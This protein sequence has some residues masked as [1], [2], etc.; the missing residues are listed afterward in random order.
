MPINSELIRYTELN[1][2]TL[3]ALL[4]DET[5]SDKDRSLVASAIAI[6]NIR[7]SADQEQRINF[8]SQHADRVTKVYDEKIEDLNGDI[9]SLKGNLAEQG[10]ELDKNKADLQHAQEVHR[11]II[12]GMNDVRREDLKKM[13][14]K[15]IKELKCK[16]KAATTSTGAAGIVSL[17]TS[18]T[19]L[20]GMIACP[21]SIPATL[22]M[23]LG[24]AAAGMGSGLAHGLGTEPYAK[25]LEGKVW[26]LEKFPESQRSDLIKKD[27]ENLY[28][29]YTKELN[30]A[31][32]SAYDRLDDTTDSQQ[33]K[34]MEEEYARLSS[35]AWNSLCAEAATLRTRVDADFYI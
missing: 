15:D 31:H 4:V 29:A 19:G 35:I 12:K 34:E 10:A 17:A 11:T 9:S 13:A 7:T 28:A 24:G 33:E 3:S 16:A 2:K 25:K 18:I 23:F 8:L 21:P 6:K 1:I 22:P 20:V 26:V 32:S 30:A 27:A 5:I 14:K